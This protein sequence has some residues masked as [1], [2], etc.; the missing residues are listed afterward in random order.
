MIR[1][2]TLQPLATL[3]LGIVCLTC[4]IVLAATGVTLL[5]YYVPYHEVA[6]D[7]ILHIMTTLRY[8]KLIRNLHYLAANV[9]FIAGLLHLARVFFTGSYQGRFLNWVYG[10][11]LLCAYPCQQLYR[12]PPAL[13]P[14]II[15]G[16]QSGLQSR[17]VLPGRRAIDQAVSPGG[18]GNRTRDP[19]PFVYA[20]RC[21][22][23]GFVG[24]SSL[25][26]TCGVSGK[27]GAW[28]PPTSRSLREIAS[29]PVLFR[30]ELAVGLLT[31]S[32]ISPYRS[33][34]KLRC[35]AG[36]ILCVRPTR[37]KHPGTLWASRKW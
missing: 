20:A 14:D 33:S 2:R 34:S 7:R 18:R 9:L 1:E 17:H 6:Y 37:P 12:L 32:L 30:A 28:Q 29:S 8:G 5:L 15:L 4:L 26:C 13:G 19:D 22:P 25:P 31:L 23:A 24:D 21:A 3:G 16:H 35:R 11:L 27:T 10:L 36:P